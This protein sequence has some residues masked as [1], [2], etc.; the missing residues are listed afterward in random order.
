MAAVWLG[1]AVAA[2]PL[3]SAARGPEPDGRARAIGEMAGAAQAFLAAL[4]A[5]QRAEATFAWDDGE[6]ENWHFVPIE[7][8]GLPVRSMRPDQ[9]ALAFALLGSGMSQRGFVQASTIMSLE[10]ILR[11]IEN[12]PD[13]RDPEKYYVSVFGEP[14]PGA[15]WGWR[16]EGHHLAVNFTVV[17][18]ERVSGTPSFF[19]TNPAE[20][21]S[22]P[23]AGLRPLGEEEDLGRE[24]ARALA[25]SGA[26]VV[27]GGTAPDDVLSGQLPKAEPLAADGVL[28]GEMAPEQ[29]AVAER[30]VQTYLG[31]YR[32][33]LAADDLAEIAA[34]G[35]DKVRFA[36]AGGMEVGQPHY[37]RVQGPTFLLEY[38]NTQNDANHAH[39]TWREF[40]GDFG[41]D[42][43]AEHYREAH[44]QGPR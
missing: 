14:R 22:G 25:A 28:L 4:D 12:A 23:R 17:N 33:A 10:Q 41:R 43:L 29:R 8:K 44:G 13:R 2:G 11:E 24:L 42:L 36:W 27:I 21:R 31:R 34:A 18:G 16:F 32:A 1:A 20:V 3:P 6:R 40:D 37:Y 5:G 39:A 7:R 35:W 30:L 38:A 9:Q 19:G 15:T 26:A